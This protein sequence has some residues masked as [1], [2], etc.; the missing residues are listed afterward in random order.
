MYIKN[1]KSLCGNFLISRE[2]GGNKS[3]KLLGYLVTSARADPNSRSINPEYFINDS[4]TRSRNYG[5]HFHR[6]FKDS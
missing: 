6:D 5:W 1:N 2:K 3:K 4:Q